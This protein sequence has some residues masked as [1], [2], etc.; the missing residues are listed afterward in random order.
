VC[1]LLYGLGFRSLFGDLV[2]IWWWLFEGC[3]GAL[4]DDQGCIGYNCLMW[5]LMGGFNWCFCYVFLES[6]FAMFTR[7]KVSIYH[8]WHFWSLL[9]TLLLPQFWSVSW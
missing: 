6:V 5:R 7:R 2:C 9:K 1:V 4:W 3:G 8:D